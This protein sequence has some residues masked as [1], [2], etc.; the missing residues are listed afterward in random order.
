MDYR[1][2]YSM[3]AGAQLISPANEPPPNPFL[4]ET[5]PAPKET[6]D[7]LESFSRFQNIYN[8]PLNST[9]R[10]V[11]L[12]TLDEKSNDNSEMDSVFD[13][14]LNTTTSS[15]RKRK[16]ESPEYFT[17]VK[18][19]RDKSFSEKKKRVSNFFKTPINYFSQ[20][21]RTIHSTSFNG[22]LNESVISSS[23]VFNV[24]TVQDLSVG[25]CETP[26]SKKSKKNLLRR[27]FSSKFSTSKKKLKMDFDTSK[28]SLVEGGGC[29]ADEVDKLNTSCFPAI[30]R[31][32]AIPSLAPD[33][34]EPSNELTRELKGL[35]V[36]STAVLTSFHSQL[37]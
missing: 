18:R 19:K 2:G 6:I 3:D 11:F 36:T 9:A 5:P 14:T 34:T 1:E 10:S 26:V 8:T 27:T 17:N 21:R 24:D 31:V 25:R 30:G 15:N 16:M 37:T 32:P 4:N 7:D 12:E 29:D 35:S 33:Q 22:S 20:R 23:G 28:L 13:Q